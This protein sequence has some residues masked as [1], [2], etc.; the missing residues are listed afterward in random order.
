MFLFDDNSFMKPVSELFFS[1]GVWPRVAIHLLFL[2]MLLGSCHSGERLH[3]HA[4][5]VEGGYGYVVLY[6]QDTVIFQPYMPAVGRRVPFASRQH[7]QAVGLLVCRKLAE[8]QP[9]AVTREEVE[10]LKK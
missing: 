2:C 8:R 1:T 6:G 5:Q 10:A 3:S 7:A 9:P 4:V